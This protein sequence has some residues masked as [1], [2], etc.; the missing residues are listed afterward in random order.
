L[1]KLFYWIKLK[2]T[3]LYDILPELSQYMMRTELRCISYLEREVK[4]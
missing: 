4:T 2:D 1:E 3:A